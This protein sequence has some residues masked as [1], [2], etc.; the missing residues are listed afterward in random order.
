MPLEIRVTDRSGTHL[1]RLDY[2]Q[3]TTVYSR[4]QS[5]IV[6]PALQL[7]GKI[8]GGDIVTNDSNVI[9]LPC[10]QFGSEK[11]LQRFKVDLPD[12]SVEIIAY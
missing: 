7:Y 11:M 9:H 4:S 12:K 5:G 2:D 3:I 1:S 8:V 6:S 10:F